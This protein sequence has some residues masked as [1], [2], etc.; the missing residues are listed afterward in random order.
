MS[1]VDNDGRKGNGRTGDSWP[2]SFAMH[3]LMTV[4]VSAIFA[5]GTT[6]TLTQTDLFD[7]GKAMAGKMGELE[8]SV[9]GVDRTVQKIDGAVGTIDYN[10]VEFERRQVEKMATNHRNTT[11]SLSTLNDV[12]ASLATRATDLVDVS[13][14]RSGLADLKELL[15]KQYGLTEKMLSAA[16]KDRADG[17]TLLLEAMREIADTHARRQKAIKEMIDGIEK[18]GDEAIDERDHDRVGEWLALAHFVVSSL[19]LPERDGILV[20]RSVVATEISVAKKKFSKSSGE[21]ALSH[22][23]RALVAV[24]AVQEVVNAERL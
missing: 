5:S 1:Q 10:L 19:A 22:A 23:R 18:E 7:L 15:W 24:R 9:E 14:L 20:D 16:Q 12:T 2:A 13:E 21:K 6:L 3:T 17:R 11:M 4:I 8:R